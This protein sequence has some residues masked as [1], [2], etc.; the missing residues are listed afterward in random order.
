MKL[1]KEQILQIENYLTNKEIKYIDIRFEILDHIISDVEFII[2]NKNISF[3]EALDEVKLKWDKSLRL[4]S[5]LFL[6]YTNLGPSIF[7]N[8]C[9]KIYKPLWL[10]T[11]ISMVFFLVLIYAILEFFKLDLLYFYS[12]IKLLYILTILIFTGTLLF[13]RIKIKR[14]K[15]K[16]SFSYL[17]NKQVF[18]NIFFILILLDN[19]FDEK[20]EN[21]DFFDLAMLSIT[22]SIVLIGNSLYKNHAKT[23]SN[24]NNI[25]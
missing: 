13:W 14:N 4:K 20:P 21:I 18:P 3:E 11:I 24:Y 10:K 5:S 8:K 6:G 12:V 9:V 17:L 23:V 15:L 16:T 22:V 1:T 2:K 7:I 19:L 25:G